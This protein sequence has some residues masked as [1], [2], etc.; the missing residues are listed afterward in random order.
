MPI[1]K[2][3]IT[4]INSNN[5]SQ[6]KS[7][8]VHPLPIF[9]EISKEFLSDL[10]IKLFNNKSFRTYDDIASFAFW[11]RKSNIEK[12]AFDYSTQNY[13]L[14]R[15]IAL[16]IT[17]SN[18]PVNFAFS[19]AFGLLSGCANIVRIPSD[20]FNQIEIICSEIFD[21]LSKN[22]YISLSKMNEFITYEKDSEINQELS[23]IANV[24]LIW[25]GDKTIYELKKVRT[26]P[27]CLDVCFSD[28][29]SFCIINSKKFNYLDNE[30]KQILVNKF[31]ND[32]F[33]L[34]QNACSS[35]FLIIWEGDS[36][37][38]NKAKSSF[39]SFVNKKINQ[40]LVLEDS[41]IMEKFRHL[42]KTSIDYHHELNINWENNM[43]YRL[44]LKKMSDDF[45]KFKF[46]SGFFFEYST[47][48]INEIWEVI[49]EKYQT[50]TYYGI[51][52]ETIFNSLKK[53]NV[54]G[55]DRIVPIGQALEIGHIW[56]GFDII[57]TLS[58]C[59]SVKE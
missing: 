6:I 17:P 43:I 14:G 19:F 26:N 1:N 18:V 29:Y 13:F 20:K 54:L 51:K 55:V 16:H 24:R 40:K 47:N 5:I 37:N 41:E 4:K 44:N 39:W 35:P 48:N 49:N 2:R 42:C 34:N 11:C 8:E 52:P 25:G 7:I 31:Y 38:C 46:R 32:A 36:K 58:R 3:T 33:Y 27:R 57:R 10:S 53:A 22:K 23:K 59:I 12:I 21:L 30:Q 28:R 56:D 45:Y 15:G 9:S 50:I